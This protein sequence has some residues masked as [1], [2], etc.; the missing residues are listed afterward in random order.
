V[1]TAILNDP[2]GS[3]GYRVK[4]KYC[5]VADIE[6]ILSQRDKIFSDRSMARILWS[7]I[8]PTRKRSFDLGEKRALSADG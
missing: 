1:R 7:M 2:D 4:F 5:Y 6:H 8:R 3:S